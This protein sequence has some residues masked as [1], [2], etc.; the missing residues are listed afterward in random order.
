[1]RNVCIICAI[2]QET[3]LILAKLPRSASGSIAAFSSWKTTVADNCITVIESGIGQENAG[4]AASAAVLQIKPDL[5]INAGF[6]GAITADLHTGDI[7]SSSF[8]HNLTAGTIKEKI[9]PDQTLQV[10]MF[11]GIANVDFISA[12]SIY[13]KLDIRTLLPSAN[14]AVIEMESFAVASICNECRIPFIAIR[15]VSDDFTTDPSH[16]FKAIS[17]PDFKINSRTLVPAIIR[18][19]SLLC[20]LPK[21]AKGAR[22]AGNSLATALANVLEDL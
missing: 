7:V 3:R 10:S 18:K 21:L 12:D 14:T 5:I 17:G 1:M 15:A 8:I 13:E 11:R 9:S 4:K 6:C 16:L 19:P 20:L 2:S 22:V